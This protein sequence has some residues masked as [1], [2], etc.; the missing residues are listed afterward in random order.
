MSSLLLRITV[1]SAVA[2]ALSACAPRIRPAPAD[3]VSSDLTGLTLDPS[4]EGSRLY[5]RPGAPPFGSYRRFIIDPVRV[6]YSDP[7]MAELDVEEVS[8]IQHSFRDSLI[9]ELREAGYEV[10]TRSQAD[11]MRISLTISRL[12]APSAAAN[13]SGLAAPIAIS[14]GEVTIEG[15]FRESLSDRVD[16]VVVTSA[17]GSR[18]LNPKPWSTWADVDSALERWAKNFRHA[19]D[20]A[21][22]Q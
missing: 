12:K 9:T 6:T 11:T 8:R 4:Q 2:L 3:A 20:E 21:H 1:V 15:V 22:Q 10:G 16:A 18:V 7:D 19:V 13:V 17:A 14:V 5:R